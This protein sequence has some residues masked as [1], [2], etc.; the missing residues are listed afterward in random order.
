MQAEMS[1][2]WERGRRDDR[3]QRCRSLNAAITPTLSGVAKG[4]WRVGVKTPLPLAVD[5]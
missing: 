5:G 3:R 4:A 2:E 1:K